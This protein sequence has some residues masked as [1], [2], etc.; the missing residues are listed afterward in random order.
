MRGKE[1][2]KRKNNDE[3][4]YLIGKAVGRFTMEMQIG[5]PDDRVWTFR[6]EYR[7]A[8]RSAGYEDLRI[9]GPRLAKSPILRNWSHHNCIEK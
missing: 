9:N 4:L 7:N 8:L 2:C 6:R 1:R 5:D 3:Q